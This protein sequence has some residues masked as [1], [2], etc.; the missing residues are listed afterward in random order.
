MLVIKKA[1]FEQQPCYCCT[2]QEHNV[3][4]KNSSVVY[5]L[6]HRVPDGDHQISCRVMVPR[7]KHCAEKMAPA[8]NIALVLAILATVLTMVAGILGKGVGTGIFMGLL[9]GVV[10]FFLLSYVVNLAFQQVYKQ[11]VEEYEV[12]RVLMKTYGWQT[13]E[14]KKGEK[15]PSFTPFTIDAMVADLQ[16]NWGCEVTTT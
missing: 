16:N 10:S 4:D 1:N 12:V 7:C 15:D 14:V 8:V 13:A 11:N 2:S 6:H 5:D 3:C 9:V